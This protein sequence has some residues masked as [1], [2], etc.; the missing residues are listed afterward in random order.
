MSPALTIFLWGLAFLATH[1]IPVHP[2]VRKALIG[3][4]G[5]RA[6]LVLYSLLS[7]ATLLPWVSVWWKNR[8]A[9]PLLWD[10]RGV[11]GLTHIVELGVVLAFALMVGGALTPAPSSHLYRGKAIGVRGVVAITR[12]PLMMGIGLW[13]ACHALVNGWAGDLAFFGLFA[14]SAWGGAWHQ[15]LRKTEANPA[16]AEFKEKT[17]FFPWPTPSALA[18][19]GARGWITMGMGAFLAVV[20]RMF[21]PFLFG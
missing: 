2:P 11:P 18:A 7:F 4:L 6:Y 9:G 1:H 3:V 17:S 8:H 12:H 13:A 5:E 21:H 20:V 19:V 10:L 15:D 16:Y 14:L